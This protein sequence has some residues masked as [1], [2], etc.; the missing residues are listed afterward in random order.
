MCLH[1]GGPSPWWTRSTRVTR[2]SATTRR[3]LGRRRVGRSQSVSHA[4]VPQHAK[5]VQRLRAVT[6]NLTDMFW[7]WQLACDGHPEDFQHILTRYVGQWLRRCYGS[8]PSGILKYDLFAFQRIKVVRCRPC[9]YV[10]YFLLRFETRSPQRWLG[11]RKSKQNLAIFSLC[12]I[13]RGVATCPSQDFKFLRGPNKFLRGPNFWY[14]CSAVHL[15]GLGD[16]NCYQPVLFLLGG[17]FVR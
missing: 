6:D 15:R 12:K 5:R 16:S 8:S 2:R 17:D 9:C 13:M 11:G 7:R 10:V 14:S 3:P 1:V 4:V